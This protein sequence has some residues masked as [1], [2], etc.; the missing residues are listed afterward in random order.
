[1]PY[2]LFDPA[3]SGTGNNLLKNVEIKTRTIRVMPYWKRYVRLIEVYNKHEHFYRVE[4]TDVG[5]IYSTEDFMRPTRESA[6]KLFEQKAY[7]PVREQQWEVVKK[8]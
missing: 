2:S 3:N 8:R 1:M 6:E 7:F 5:R 4:V